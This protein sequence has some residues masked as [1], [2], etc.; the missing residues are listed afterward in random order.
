LLAAGVRKKWHPTGLKSAAENSRN[1]IAESLLLLFFLKLYT[2]NAG[3]LLLLLLL[4]L[5]RTIDYTDT[6]KKLYIRISA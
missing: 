2:L 4:L 6:R 3:I 1:P 5:L